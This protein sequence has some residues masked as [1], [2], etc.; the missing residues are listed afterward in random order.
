MSED[1]ITIAE[2]STNLHAIDTVAG[3]REER[4]GWPSH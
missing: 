1:L 3:A 4:Y 2:V